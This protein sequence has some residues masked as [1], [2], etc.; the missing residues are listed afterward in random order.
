MQDIKIK[1]WEE[2]KQIHK[3]KF[4]NESDYLSF[5]RD[6]VLH[7]TSTREKYTSQTKD[8]VIEGVTW[9]KEFSKFHQRY[10]DG[11]SYKFS[12]NN[13]I[14]NIGH[15]TTYLIKP[16][17][18]AY[19]AVRKIMRNWLIKRLKDEYV[20]KKPVIYNPPKSLNPRR[21]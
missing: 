12:E 2:L 5:F 19:H 16:Q 4:K 14:L 7:D 17:F 13:T 11:Y 8:R 9:A 21:K 6:V 10:K 3:E 18:A 15:Q 20:K 1:P